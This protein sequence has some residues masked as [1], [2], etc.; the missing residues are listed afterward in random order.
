M[1]EEIQKK[2]DLLKPS[3]TVYL[4]EEGLQGEEIPSNITWENVDVDSIQVTFVKPM[5]V[6]EV[7][8]TGSFSIKQTVSKLNG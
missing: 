2:P 8:N 4:P 7:F 3:C 1:P 5:I 6:K